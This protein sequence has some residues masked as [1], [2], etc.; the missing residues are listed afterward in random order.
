MLREA[1]SE[2]AL[3]EQNEI[4]D[5]EFIFPLAGFGARGPSGTVEANLVPFLDFQ[6]VITQACVWWESSGSG[7]PGFGK[8]LA[9]SAL[10]FPPL[11]D[12]GLE[13]GNW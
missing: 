5:L 1:D 3:V 11:C 7:S 4:Q 13:L 10:W 6:W 8:S 2:G 9:P 12:E